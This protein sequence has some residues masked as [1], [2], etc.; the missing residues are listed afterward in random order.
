MLYMNC[1]RRSLHRKDEGGPDIGAG[2][3]IVSSR[4]MDIYDRV[5]AVDIS[6]KMLE[7]AAQKGIYCIKARAEELPF[8]SSA[9]D[10]VVGAQCLHWFDTEL[11]LREIRRVLKVSERL[12]C[13]G[14]THWNQKLP[15]LY[16]I[17]LQT[18]IYRRFRQEVSERLMCRKY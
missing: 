15:M 17:E 11:S 5:V 7:Y 2:T 14:G 8:E 13:G 10:L 18:S 3:G 16:G 6:A 12:D 9:F 4:L 1:F